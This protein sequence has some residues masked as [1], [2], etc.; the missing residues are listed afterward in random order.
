VADAPSPKRALQL[1][2]EYLQVAR[3]L[4]P[5][6]VTNYSRD[7]AAFMGKKSTIPTE[8]PEV[9]RWLASMNANSPR[10]NA[11]RL[12]ALRQ[13]YAY[14]LQKGWVAENPTTDIATPKQPQ[15]LPKALT[16]PQV[17]A[18]LKAPLGDGPS[19]V[20]LRLI[21]HLLYASGVRVSELSNLSL[22]DVQQAE[23][24]W[25]RVTG[26]GS[27]TRPVPLGPVVQGLLHTYLT[28][29]RPRLRGAQGPWLLA[30]PSG[31]KP[32]TRVRIFQ[33]VQDAG[34]RVGVKVAPHHLRHTFATHLLEGD[35]D[36]RAVQLMLGHASLNTTQIYTKLNAQ[37]L[38]G[39]LEA[40][41]PLSRSQFGKRG[42]A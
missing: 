41:H 10:S 36:L 34:R 6:T 40:H 32:L 16:E 31:K 20:R 11:R 29:A 30:G 15:T 2:A 17:Q 12:S 38:K 18:L 33:L 23:G 9:E 26:K 27:K 14:A 13:F 37:R 21:L 5:H 19:E 1:W 22:H 4:S 7:G 8:R 25:L 3:G 42:K 28:E 24:P 35:A 39:V